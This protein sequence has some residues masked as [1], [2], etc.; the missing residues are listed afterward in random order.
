MSTLDLI[1]NRYGLLLTLA[2]VGELFHRSPAAIRQALARG[3]GIG[4]D[5]KDAQVKKGRRIYF[6]AG[7]VAKAIDG[8][9]E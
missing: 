9:K 5:L 7:D 1:L 2:Q 8:G 4:I 3:A 6:R